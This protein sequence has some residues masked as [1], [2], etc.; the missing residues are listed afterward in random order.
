MLNTIHYLDGVPP[1]PLR[2]ESTSFSSDYR[3]L[4]FRGPSEAGSGSLRS[5]AS[6]QPGLQFGSIIQRPTSNPPGTFEPLWSRSRLH[7]EGQKI[8]FSTADDHGSDVESTIRNYT[9]TGDQQSVLSVIRN[10]PNLGRLLVEAVAPLRRSF[11]ENV[12]L[13]LDL[14]VGDE[15]PTLR[16]VA[17]VPAAFPGPEAA[18]ARFDTGWW[19][20]NWHRGGAMVN[21]DWESRNVF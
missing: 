12:V 18:L 15:D 2:R 13:R 4:S 16:A 11:G 17:V 14:L 21:F 19:L 20:D 8:R 1:P 7:G 9:I 10:R 5:L 3:S 6:E